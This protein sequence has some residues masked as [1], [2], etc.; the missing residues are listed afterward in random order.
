LE[1]HT[2]NDAA[3]AKLANGLLRYARSAPLTPK[4]TSVV[5]V[6]GDTWAKRLGQMGVVMTRSATV[7]ASADVLIVDPDADVDP[8]AVEKLAAAGGRVLVLPEEGSHSIFG[9]TYTQRAG[10]H[11]SLNV[12]NW[13]ECRGISESDLHV[14]AAHTDWLIAGGAQVG[15]DGLL[16]RRVVGK[17]VI[18][19]TQTDPE[20][21]DADK[22]TY[23]RFSRWRQSHALCQII[24][25]LGASF[26][27]DAQFFVPAVRSKPDKPDPLWHMPGPPPENKVGLYY[28]DYRTDF[29]LGDDPHRYCGW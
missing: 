19:F 16:A 7:P 23:F 24:S 26:V 22:L 13:P 27:Q 14:R 21:F 9:V 5:Y 6:G 29:D 18:L 2:A 25:N 4:A 11:G 12:P 8:A 20:R 1:D 3:A 28:P 15:A 17:G 10:A